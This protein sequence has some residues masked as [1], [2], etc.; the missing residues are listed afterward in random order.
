MDE[1]ERMAQAAAGKA[2]SMLPEFDMPDDPPEDDPDDVALANVVAELGNDSA[3][4]VV[5]VYQIDDKKGRAFVGT[6][7]PVDFSIALIQTQFGAGEYRV[8]VRQNKKWLKKTTVRIAAPKNNPLL[9][10]AQVPQVETGKIIETMQSGFK[11]MGTMFANALAGLAAN[12]PKPKTTMEMLQELQM[13]REIMGGNQPAAPAGPDPM[14]LFEMATEIADK[15]NPRQGE[16]GAGEIVLNAIKEFGPVIS[17]AAQNAAMNRPQVTPITPQLHQSQAPVLQQNPNVP[18]N[19]QMNLAAAMQAQARKMYLN[20]L[21]G[22]AEKDNDPATYAQLMLDVAGEEQAL[23]FANAPD[24][25]E[26]LCAEE[27]RAAAHRA[28]FDELRNMVLELTKP[29][30]PDMNTEGQAQTEPT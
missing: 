19:E 17:Q 15:I 1:A 29:E 11:E 26:R 12:Q 5:N 9:I 6:F 20:L 14:K 4:A 27:P 2:L 25:F 7:S 13:M 28:W 30:T 21:I 22:N 8:E 10:P 3:D 24:W 16:P 23:E 18:E